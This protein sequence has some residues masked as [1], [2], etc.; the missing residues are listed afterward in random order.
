MRDHARP[1]LST[2]LLAE[3]LFDGETS[4][5]ARPSRASGTRNYGCAHL[6]Y[7]R[8]EALSRREVPGR[9]LASSVMLAS[10]LDKVSGAPPSVARGEALRYGSLSGPPCPL[11]GQPR[12]AGEEC[13]GP[14]TSARQAMEANRLKSSRLTPQHCGGPGRSRA[15][16]PQPINRAGPV[17]RGGEVLLM[18][19]C[20]G[21]PLASPTRQPCERKSHKPRIKT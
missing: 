13:R 20:S 8:K 12:T 2:C 18:R 9:P 3:Q 21:T 16:R 17:G 1:F 4:C 6:S 15:T 19:A 5:S 11:P 14:R 10:S 7:R